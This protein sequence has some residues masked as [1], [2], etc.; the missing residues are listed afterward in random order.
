MPLLHPNL[1]ATLT[2]LDRANFVVVV[3][4][5]ARLR[6][7]R[8]LRIE[9]DCPTDGM[10]GGAVVRELFEDTNTFIP[11][12]FHD[13]LNRGCVSHSFDGGATWTR[14]TGYSRSEIDAIFRELLED[15]GCPAWKAAMIFDGVEEFGQS[16]WD[17]HAKER[18]WA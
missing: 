15:N 10:S 4:I 17:N 6:D 11:S 9:T 16:A 3:P 8:L 13:A 14:W 18:G 12:I 1:P 7:G 5:V 2:T